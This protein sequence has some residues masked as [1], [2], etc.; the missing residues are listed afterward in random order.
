MKQSESNFRRYNPNSQHE[1]YTSPHFDIQG[2]FDSLFAH[3]TNKYEGWVDDAWEEY[4]RIIKIYK[5]SIEMDASLDDDD[6]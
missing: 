4:Q 5:K 1:I 6:E 2:L 3:P